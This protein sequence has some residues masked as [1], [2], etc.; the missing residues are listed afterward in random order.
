MTRNKAIQFWTEHNLQN[1]Q[2]KQKTMLSPSEIEDL[3]HFF[4]YGPHDWLDGEDEDQKIKRISKFQV[5][6][7]IKQNAQ[8]IK[9]LT[10]QKMKKSLEGLEVILSTPDFTWYR[11]VTAQAMKREGQLMANCIGGLYNSSISIYSL[12]TNNKPRVH[13]GLTP[14]NRI[15]EI[16]TFANKTDLT[17]FKEPMLALF[18]LLQKNNLSDPQQHLLQFGLFLEN[19]AI[20]PVLNDEMNWTKI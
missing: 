9:T 12:H 20:L 8:W 6:A 5:P 17:S 7:V 14:R 3:I 18:N 4:Q 2:A 1:Y 11:L 13:L 10:N 16:R 15:T 19:K